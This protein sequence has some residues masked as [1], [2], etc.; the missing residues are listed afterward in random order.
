MVDEKTEAYMRTVLGITP[1]PPG[2]SAYS[3]YEQIASQISPGLGS[4]GSSSS[5]GA[6]SPPP[7]HPSGGIA[8][9]STSN[10][11]GKIKTEGTEVTTLMFPEVPESQKKAQ[12]AAIRKYQ[13]DE[14]LTVNEARLL[15]F[16][17][18]TKTPIEHKGGK[19]G[20]G[21]YESRDV[22]YTPEGG[23]ITGFIF[24][25]PKQTYSRVSE[26]EEYQRRLAAQGLPN[27][28]T[29]PPSEEIHIKGAGRTLFEPSYTAMPV[30]PLNAFPFTIST[31]YQT[32]Q[33]YDRAIKNPRVVTKE[34]EI[35]PDR[36]IF[37]FGVTSGTASEWVEKNIY[38][39]TAGGAFRQSWVIRE[40]EKAGGA[41]KATLD[42]AEGIVKGA[43][44]FPAYIP[45][46]GIDVA[47]QTWAMATDRRY[48]GAKKEVELRAS[49][50]SKLGT[51][52]SPLLTQ[53]EL[54]AVGAYGGELAKAGPSMAGFIIGGS[55][56][57]SMMRSASQKQYAKEAK[58]AEIQNAKIRAELKNQV[59]TGLRYTQE[60][61]GGKLT[62]R[63]H[64]D[65][66][67]IPKG[68]K[69]TEGPVKAD[70][71]KMTQHFSLH[72]RKGFTQYETGTATLTP[73]VSTYRL[74]LPGKTV[75]VPMSG[76]VFLSDSPAVIATGSRGPIYSGSTAV[77][78]TRGA[79]FK[80]YFS[81]DGYV[82]GAISPILESQSFTEN[83]ANL[84][85]KID[86]SETAGS[87]ITGSRSL[88]TVGKA[89][90]MKDITTS[91]FDFRQQFQGSKALNIIKGKGEY[92][93]IST[94]YEFTGI[95]QLI[96]QANRAAQKNI[97]IKPS[98]SPTGTSGLLKLEGAKLPGGQTTPTATPTPPRM[99]RFNTGSQGASQVTLTQPVEVNMPSWVLGM[100]REQTFQQMK[101][102]PTM[103]QALPT[104]TMPMTQTKQ[105][106]K[107]VFK[108]PNTRQQINLAGTMTRQREKEVLIPQLPSMT[109]ELRFSREAKVLLPRTAASVAT[110]LKP[111]LDEVLI[112]KEKTKEKETL[113]PRMPELTL[114]LQRTRQTSTPFVPYN[115]PPGT[116]INPGGGG[117]IE[118]PMF[119]TSG[120][121]RGH[122]ISKLTI[123]KP[124]YKPSVAAVSLNIK[125]MKPIGIGSGISIRPITLKNMTSRKKK[126]SR[127]KRKRRR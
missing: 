108:L 74:M 68:M 85:Y 2:S 95:K 111:R 81:T 43:V 59:P 75:N 63:Y 49:G 44:F 101:V 91:P 124:H 62:Y 65:M 112:Y 56:S 53:E 82:S 70:F 61:Y 24:S 122:R 123:P 110:S 121:G 19:Y 77:A 57:A 72:G 78:A 11:E 13:R 30:D 45:A 20:Q 35:K 89:V 99:S 98:V 52:C 92:K 105:V 106:Q 3:E 36:G 73:V 113:L 15:G 71:G 86:I 69:F 17:V 79:S 104:M 118:F 100:A 83:I 58:A 33:A 9:G 84:H 93:G 7:S 34:Q 37:G 18:E 80:Q 109:K 117:G 127:K 1:P 125:G 21:Q 90:I 97:H 48:E 39:T 64:W 23:G 102:T 114:Q 27:T 40:M 120:M 42:F 4:G 66:E 88:G 76:Q 10:S 115:P 31:P 103:G 50:I 6:S 5:G 119:G 60:Q 87:Y 54:R 26:T 29:P 46:M 28:Y 22:V 96:E 116:L 8:Q 32:I 67:P 16:G 47:T 107:Q 55:M 38:Q 12:I 41:S 126:R 94:A 51:L 14:A 25:Q